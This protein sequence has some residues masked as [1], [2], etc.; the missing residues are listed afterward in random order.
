MMSKTMKTKYEDMARML[1]YGVAGG[2]AAYAADLLT[3]AGVTPEHLISSGGPACAVTDLLD[4]GKDI[5][6]GRLATDIGLLVGTY[7][8][9]DI[10]QSFDQGVQAITEGAY[11]KLPMLAAAVA[12]P[13]VYKGLEKAVQGAYNHFRRD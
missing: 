8:G 4:M 1:R 5:S 13:I 10:Y 7:L 6:K 9:P 12:V 3:T 2:G 11:E